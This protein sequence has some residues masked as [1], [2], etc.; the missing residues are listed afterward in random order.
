MVPIVPTVYYCMSELF[1]SY[2]KITLHSKRFF[3]DCKDKGLNTQCRRV[4]TAE[5]P[6][7]NTATNHTNALTESVSQTR[8]KSRFMLY[9]NNIFTLFYYHELYNIILLK[10][11]R[12]VS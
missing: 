10:H 9:D 6:V 5:K 2:N 7:Y 12:T 3:V 8:G 1:F 11:N 4:T